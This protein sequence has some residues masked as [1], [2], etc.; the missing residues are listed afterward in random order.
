MSTNVYRDLV[1]GNPADVPNIIEYG[2]MPDYSTDSSAAIQAAID[3]APDGGAVYMP[4]G[5]YKFTSKCLG[6]IDRNHL[7]LYGDGIG[8][9]ILDCS[10]VI[11]MPPPD[12]YAAM[13]ALEGTSGTIVVDT[14]TFGTVSTGITLRDFTLIVANNAAS[15][16]SFKALTIGS[17]D[18]C[19]IERV[20]LYGSYWEGIYHYD[21]NGNLDH[22]SSRNWIV[23]F[24]EGE[25]NRSSF[26][27]SN[28]AWLESYAIHDNYSHDSVS[29]NGGCLMV[30]SRGYITRNRFVRVGGRLTSISESNFKDI[31]IANNI[32]QDIRAHDGGDCIVLQILQDQIADVDNGRVILANNIIDKIDATVAAIGIQIKGGTTLCIGNI[33]GGRVN[34]AAGNAVGFDIGPGEIALPTNVQ[35][36]GNQ[37]GPTDSGTNFNYGISISGADVHVFLDGNT[38]FAG[39]ANGALYVAAESDVLIGEN[40]FEGQVAVGAHYRNSYKG[41][42]DD[43]HVFYDLPAGAN[44]DLRGHEL[45]WA[46]AASPITYTDFTPNY[47]GQRVEMHFQNSNITISDT[48]KIRLAGGAAFASSNFDVLTM[49]HDGFRWHEVSRSVNS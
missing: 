13:A 34:G 21:K 6:I 12:A 42:F 16:Q 30:G 9:T 4:R 29:G 45:Y 33:V 8:Q 37:V 1:I 23:R 40:Q 48:D 38:V 32:F 39:A 3:A 5:H 14:S 20:K 25:A 36:I 31:V 27:N 2:A 15:P 18:T 47:A 44:P 26:I 41:L 43:T 17:T 46:S 24:C 19:I 10:D 35:L 49:R 7:T 11:D 22:D 28:D